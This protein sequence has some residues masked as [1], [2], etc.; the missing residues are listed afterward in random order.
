MTGRPPSSRSRTRPGGRAVELLLKDCQWETT[1]KE[2]GLQP[3][4]Q[5]ESPPG[6]ER[7]IGPRSQQVEDQ[8]E[9]NVGGDRFDQP[10]QAGEQGQDGGEGGGARHDTAPLSVGSGVE[11][12]GQGEGGGHDQEAL[13]ARAGVPGV[14]Q[15]AAGR[16]AVG[17]HALAGLNGG[18]WGEQL[19]PGP[20]SRESQPE[21]M[22]LA[23]RPSRSV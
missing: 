22:G 15:Q 5:A 19:A 6:P 11:G 13:S 14:Q 23:V 20:P 16:G 18:G 1:S 12:K 10:G 3:A 21:V 2:P 4:H 17:H 7:V 9:A 8:P